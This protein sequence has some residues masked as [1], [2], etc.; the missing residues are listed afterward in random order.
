[1][2]LHSL[3]NYRLTDIKEHSFEVCDF[4]KKIDFFYNLIINL[5]VSLFA[6]TFADMLTREAAFTIY[7]TLTL[8]APTKEFEVQALKEKEVR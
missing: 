7:K 6:E 8:A 5:Q 2:S 3:L 4:W 1:M